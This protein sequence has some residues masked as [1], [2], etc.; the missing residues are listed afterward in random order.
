[1]TYFRRV[2]HPFL[3]KQPFL[4]NTATGCIMLWTHRQPN[5][6][7]APAVSNNVLGAA[8]VIPSLADFAE[9][10]SALPALIDEQG[11][12]FK[13]LRHCLLVLED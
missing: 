5:C 6:A 12:S 11:L 3:L 8:V 9:A 1:M 2:Y 7:Q 4:H 13:T 10:A